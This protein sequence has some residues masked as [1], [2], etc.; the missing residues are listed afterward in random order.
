MRGSNSPLIGFSTATTFL[1]LF[2][3]VFFLGLIIKLA[4]GWSLLETQELT[5]YMIGPE[6]SVEMAWAIQLMPQMALM[7]RVMVDGKYWHWALIGVAIAFNVI[8]FGTNAIAISAAVHTVP[9]SWPTGAFMGVTVAD[10]ADLFTY[11]IAF[12]ITWAEEALA[13]G[14]GM[15]L[16]FAAMILKD[17]GI[18]VP[19]ALAVSENYARAASG[20][21]NYDRSS[22]AI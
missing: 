22:N 2:G 14:I 17:F 13:L 8:D 18:S 9:A 21:S 12:A 3:T 16:H 6:F 4:F 19:N 20:L 7:L 10:L 15:A 1:K 11:F 5:T